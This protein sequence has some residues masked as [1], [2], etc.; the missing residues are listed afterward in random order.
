M[1]LARHKRFLILA[2]CALWTT[3]AWAQPAAGVRSRLDA[4]LKPY[5]GKGTIGVVVRRLDDGR[6]LYA[7]EADTPL[8]PASV[9]KL[10]TTAAALDRFGPTFKLETRVYLDGDELLIVGGGDPGFGDQRLAE[11]HG[12]AHLGELADWA[13]QLKARGVT[14]LSKIAI[15]DSIFEQTR[16]NPGWTDDQA[17]RW[18][19]APVGGVNINDNCIDAR[20]TA[21]NGVVNVL[22]IPR[23]P[24]SLLRNTLVAAEKHEPIAARALGSDV[25]AFRGTAGKSDGLGSVACGDPTVFFGY[26][27]KQA[28]AD[29]GIGGDPEVVRRRIEKKPTVLAV[30]TTSMD[31]LLWRTNRFSQNL[32]AECLFKS[33]A[34]YE[35]DGSRSGSPGSWDGGRQV[36]RSTLAR[37]GVDIK[38]AVFRDGSGLSHDN[39][40]TPAQIV[41]VLTIMRRHPHAQAYLDSLA[42]AGAAGSMRTRYADEALSGKLMGKTGSIDGVCTVAGFIESDESGTLVFAAMINGEAPVTVLVEI[43][44]VLVG[45]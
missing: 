41:D 24:A 30:H 13:A 14:S 33:L 3:T 20:I 23:L 17:D 25:F 5:E 16:R 1:H 36:L 22:T 44:R 9:M 6:E 43:C 38:G 4:V 11:Q 10:F 28:L 2:F 26:A 34:A 19:Q 18:W 7:H 42:H 29:A 8:K 27:V 40:V 31:D 37:L 35:R 21:A 12:R 15:D 45:S 32:F 39:R